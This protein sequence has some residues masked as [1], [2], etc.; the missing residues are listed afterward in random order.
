MSLLQFCRD[1]TPL[2]TATDSCMHM[3]H[4]HTYIHMHIYILHTTY[5][6]IH[7]HKI[8]SVVVSEVTR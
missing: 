3:V 8:I 1:T 4:A 6:Y 5:I 2:L 7:T